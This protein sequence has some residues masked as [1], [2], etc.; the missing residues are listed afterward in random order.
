[1][2]A[3]DQLQSDGARSEPSAW[4]AWDG[5]RPDVAVDATH[6]RRPLLADGDAG[7]SADPARAALAQD[8]SFQPELPLAR[9][10]SAPQDAVVELYKPDAAQSAEQSCAAQGLAARQ[11]PEEQRDAAYSEPPEQHATRKR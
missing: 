4:D 2:E 11:R 3:L 9:L 6:Q 8:A 5:A 1:M 7:K 10:A